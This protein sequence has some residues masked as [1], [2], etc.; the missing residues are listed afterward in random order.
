MAKILLV[1]DDL[2]VS[3]LV[4]FQLEHDRHLVESVRFGLDALAQLEIVNFELLIIDWMLPDISGVSV[5]RQFREKGG[6]TPILMLT[7]RS[8][9]EDK[10]TA[11]D[12]GADDYLVKPFHPLELQARVR[13]LVRRASFPRGK[14]VKVQDVELNEVTCQVKR[15]GKLIELRPKEFALLEFLMKH[16]NQSFTAEAILLRLWKTDSETSVETVRTHIKRLRSKLG[17]NEENPLIRTTRHL[18]YRFVDY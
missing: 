13:A 10:A 17:D 15:A 4:Q 8:A 9:V 11:L 5:C 1:E 7:G 12:A 14:V 6:Y 18:G 3:Y 16:P 2:S